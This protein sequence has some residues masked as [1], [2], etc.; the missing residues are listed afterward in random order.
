MN[1]S[2]RWKNLNFTSEFIDERV[3]LFECNSIR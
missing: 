2:K 3:I 1:M